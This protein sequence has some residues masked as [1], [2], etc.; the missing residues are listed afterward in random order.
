M[1][2]VQYNLQFEKVSNLFQ[3]GEVVGEPKAV[4]GGLLHKMYVVETNSGKFA[5]KALNP[6]IMSRPTA[7]RNFIK[8][9]RIANL[10]AKTIPALPAK[11]IGG[12]SVQEID[13]QFYLVFDW[14]EGISL[15][16]NEVKIEN[17]EK[18][19]S[20]LAGMHMMD[21]SVLGLEKNDLI[22]E[23]L[24]DFNYYLQL[25]QNNKAVWTDLLKENI[26]NLYEW[27]A[28][29]NHSIIKLA[30]DLVISHGDLEPKNVIWNFDNPV[31]IDW[32]SAGY[33]NPMQDLVE[34]AIYWAG[35]GKGNLDKDKFLAFINGYKIKYGA[36]QANWKMVLDS[37]YLGKLGWLEYSLKRSLWIEC[38]DEEQQQAGTSQVTGTINAI[39]RYFNTT[40]E[41][42]MWLSNV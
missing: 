10:V 3:L 22:K 1:G 2:E 20:I 32:E 31:I 29:A 18:I 38:T 6:Q 21:S 33:I 24:I 34:T 25:G 39:I 19:G 11:I 41:I 26:D 27:N 40:S 12:E 35:D 36:L 14:L 28:S 8:S 13:N 37:G 5:I 4:S 16:P 23:K 9:E 15:K 30:S 17:C 42:E 7:M